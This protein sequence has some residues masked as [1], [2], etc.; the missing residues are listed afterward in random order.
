MV[1]TLLNNA[2]RLHTDKFSRPLHAQSS[3]T[4]HGSELRGIDTQQGTHDRYAIADAC[5]LEV[6]TLLREPG[7]NQA[8]SLLSNSF[9]C[10]ALVSNVVSRVL[11]PSQELLICST[12][13]E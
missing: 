12:G 3:R 8:V 11:Q 4:G 5:W 6:R 10:Q 9:G 1:W 13:S 2:R 7:A